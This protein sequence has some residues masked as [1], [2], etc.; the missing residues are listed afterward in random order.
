M[1]I[2]GGTIFFT[3]GLFQLIQAG[4]SIWNPRLILI[5]IY[6]GVFVSLVAYALLY[7]AVSR[8]GTSRVSISV[9]LIPVIVIVTGWMFLGESLT[10]IQL[11]AA[12]AVI[13]G[14]MQ[15]QRNGRDR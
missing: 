12:A 6:L 2:I 14:V 3:P 15:G 7:W 5:L 9:N 8:I 4:P 13:I 1:Q 10:L 11:I